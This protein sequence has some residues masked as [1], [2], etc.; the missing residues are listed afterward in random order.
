LENFHENHGQK[1]VGSHGKVKKL[2]TLLQRLEGVATER[3]IS[4]KT[5]RFK[6]KNPTDC[7][8]ELTVGIVSFQLL[9]QEVDNYKAGNIKNFYTN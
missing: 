3:Q 7:Q 6:Q 2:E 5:K 8:E 9:Q 4:K 1:L